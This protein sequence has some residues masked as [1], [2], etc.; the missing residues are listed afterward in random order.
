M[1]SEG[2]EI[3]FQ[4]ARE[5]FQHEEFWDKHITRPV[6]ITAPTMVCTSVGSYSSSSS[7]SL[8]VPTAPLPTTTTTTTT[9]TATANKSSSSLNRLIDE[10]C[11]L[12][13]DFHDAD[14]DRS[15]EELVAM[16]KNMGAVRLAATKQP[17]Y[18]LLNP[19]LREKQE[20]ALKWRKQ[21]RRVV[22]SLNNPIYEQPHAEQFDDTNILS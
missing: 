10:L 3:Y 1:C 4:D 19:D 13:V 21:W 8:H 15:P 17:S 22:R 2:A 16:I 6:P 5:F 18:H 11:T 12:V 7:R 9:T 14:D 20:L